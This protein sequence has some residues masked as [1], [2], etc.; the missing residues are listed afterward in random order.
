M[1]QVI[2]NME[3]EQMNMNIPEFRIGD[4]ISVHYRIIEGEKERIQVFTGVVIARK[5]KGISETI[6][7][8][9]IAYGSAMERVIPLHSPKVS[10]IEVVKRG[11]VR[12]SKLYHLRGVFGKKAKI[13]ERIIKTE[14][15]AKAAPVEEIKEEI[16]EPKATEEEEKKEE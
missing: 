16:T 5:G 1:N 10:K 11:K 9:R 2:E 13:Q 6:S 8:Y 4:T 7:I 14:S 15:R 3:A 12:K